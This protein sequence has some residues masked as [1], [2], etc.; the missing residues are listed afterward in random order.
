M[1]FADRG[2]GVPRLSAAYSQRRIILDYA[3]FNTLC[4]IALITNAFEPGK[5]LLAASIAR[6][7]LSAER[8]MIAR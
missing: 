6:S 4:M 8:M 3:H 7:R 1:P 2:G 5:P